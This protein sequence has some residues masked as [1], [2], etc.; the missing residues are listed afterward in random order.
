MIN[1]NLQIA[2]PWFKP[3]DDFDNRDFYWNDRKITTNKNL[4][5]QIS[6]F[7]AT[8]IIDIGLDLRWWGHDHAGPE[9]DINVFGYMFNIKIY[10]NRHWNWDENRWYTDD[11]AL[12]EAREQQNS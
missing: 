7:R 9:L 5:I 12:Q 10:D 8:D 11:E 6:R 1:F 3:N 2:N 4:E